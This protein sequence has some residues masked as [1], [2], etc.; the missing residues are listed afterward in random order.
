MGCYDNET[1]GC[2][3]EERH[4]NGSTTIVKDVLSP[5]TIGEGHQEDREEVDDCSITLP[6]PHHP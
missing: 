1:S 2:K 4:T 5:K 3:E 6:M